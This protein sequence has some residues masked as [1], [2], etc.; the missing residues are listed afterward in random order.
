MSV[1]RN[2]HMNKERGNLGTQPRWTRGARWA[3][4]LSGD[5]ELPSEGGRA[6]PSAGTTEAHRPLQKNTTH[7]TFITHP[8]YRKLDQVFQKSI[9]S[10]LLWIGIIYWSYLVML[11]SCGS[12]K[13]RPSS[14]VKKYCMH[15]NGENIYSKWGNG[16][17]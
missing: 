7:T 3:K 1:S 10:F 15:N 2:H 13:K 9:I 6:L 17:E 16:Y 5:G 12:F 4:A 8:T 11:N 14:W